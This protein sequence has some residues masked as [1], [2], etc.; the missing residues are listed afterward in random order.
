[1]LLEFAVKNVFSFRNEAVLCLTSTKEQLHGNTLS[2]IKYP[3]QNKILPVSIILGANAAGK[4]S[5]VKAL[6]ALQRMVVKQPG[7]GDETGIV[8][9]LLDDDCASAPSEMRVR[10]LCNEVVYELNVK[11]TSSQILYESLLRKNQRGFKT[12]YERT[13]DSISFGNFADY[14]HEEQIRLKVTYESTLQNQLFLNRCAHS[15]VPYFKPAYDWFAKI[16]FLV[17]PKTRFLPVISSADGTVS[18]TV[19]NRL[20]RE[21]GLGISSVETE[22]LDISKYPELEQA[23]RRLADGEG[24]QTTDKNKD[25]FWLLKSQGKV[26]LFKLNSMHKKSNGQLIKIKFAD[27]SDG[28]L[29]IMELSPLLAELLYARS[30]GVFIIDE[31]DRSLHPKLIR[32]LLQAYINSRNADSRTQLIAATHDVN[33][34]DQDLIRKDEI[35]FINKDD[36]GSKLMRLNDL[37]INGKAVR[38]D[39]NLR[40]AYLDGALPGVLPEIKLNTV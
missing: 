1:M 25:T 36:G 15:N 2:K 16:L 12:V 14:D 40:K 7:L 11:A 9:Y 24:R 3:T 10:F 27:E 21:L 4:T 37:K 33:L 38:F 22:T 13:P 17:G 32:D 31:L 30:K 28:T 5:L 19:L 6:G 39:V 29:R 20:L 8:P 23:G 26:L 35:W 18:T 34:L